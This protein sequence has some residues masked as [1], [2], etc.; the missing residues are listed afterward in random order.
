MSVS[1]ARGQ[2]APT[3]DALIIALQN[4]LEHLKSLCDNYKTGNYY[5]MY[6]SLN[7]VLIILTGEDDKE[8]VWCRLE[9]IKVINSLFRHEILESMMQV[10]KSKVS[11]H[12]LLEGFEKITYTIQTPA[13]VPVGTLIQFLK[14]SLSENRGP[15][16]HC[17]LSQVVSQVASWCPESLKDA[18]T[19]AAQLAEQYHSWLFSQPPP[20]STE[21][22]TPVDLGY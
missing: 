8:S 9:F 19:K 2:S 18:A 3:R 12:C 22:S 14:V 11:V 5:K 13:M 4:S 1:L 10:C 17:A 16:F 7:Y 21:C 6:S 20:P 15:N